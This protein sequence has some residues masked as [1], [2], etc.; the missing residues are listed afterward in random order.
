MGPFFTFSLSSIFKYPLR[1]KGFS[2]KNLLRLPAKMPYNLA[3]HAVQCR[4]FG[5]GQ[6]QT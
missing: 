5:L 3:Q 6:P 1:S 2:P 4:H